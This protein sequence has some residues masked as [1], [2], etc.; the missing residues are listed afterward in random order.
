MKSIQA[1]TAAPSA[2]SIMAMEDSFGGT[3]LYL[4]I[5]LHSG[6]YLRTVL[7]EVTGE[8]T[9][10]RQ[11]FLGPKPTRLFQVL[12]QNQHCVLA[13]SSRP[14]MGY[15]DPLTKGFM[16]TPLSYAELEYGWNFSSEQCQEGMV[17]IHAN[18]LRIFTIEKLG[19]NL[20]QKSVPLTYTPKR[21]VKHPDQPYFYTIES[22]NNTLPQE[23]QAKLL[24]DS[25]AVNG[26][27]RALPPE[28]FGHPKARGR[29]ASCISV[30][31]PVGEEPRVLTKI[32]LEGNEAAVSAAVVSFA[33]QDMESF[34]IVGTGK[35]MVLNPRQ[36]SEGYIHVYRFHDDGKDLEFIHKTKVEEPPLALIP[37]QGRLLQASGRRS[38]STTSVFGNCSGNR[39]QRS[40]HNLSSPFRPRVIASSLAISNRASHMSSTSTRT[41]SFFRSATIPSTDGRRVPQWSTTTLSLAATDSETSGSRGAPK[42]RAP[43][44]TRLGLRS[45]S[46][47]REAIFM[48]RLTGST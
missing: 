1:L 28:E 19:D 5:G 8:L 26:D 48:V 37:F 22:D 36:F 14:W 11:K 18:Y 46:R 35:D 7:D 17:G 34:L 10:T 16:M 23:L 43:S 2:L 25:S 30:V 3:T 6:V 40:R 44:R 31:D 47:M 38:A 9:D 39:R 15:T 42:R 45:S 12:V 29:W 13:L 41:T 4:H 21:L 32:E 27:A 20:I 33:S 24:A